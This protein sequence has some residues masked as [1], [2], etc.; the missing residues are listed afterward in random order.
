MFY[1][2]IPC[3]FRGCSILLPALLAGLCWSTQTVS[4]QENCRLVAGFEPEL[5]YH[6]LSEQG[7]IIG[8]DADILRLTLVD[9][10]CELAFQVTP[11][12]RTLVQVKNGDL[13]I[14][15]GASFK[16]ERAK[17]AHY[18]VPYRGQPHVVFENKSQGS[19]ASTLA[20]YLKSG[21]SL[22]VVLGWH[23]TNKIRALLDDP[24]YKPQIEIAPKFELAVKMHDA[25]R[26]DGFLGNPS[27]LA[28]TIGKQALY[29]KYRMI[30]AD[31]DILHYLFSRK[32]VDADL[33]KRF[34][35]RLTEKIAQGF[36]FDVCKKYENMLI[37][38][39]E[40][41]STID[42]NAGN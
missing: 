20:E 4:A 39:C 31:V 36:F 1:S 3:R 9:L 28:A 32:S 27:N 40:F 14:A 35:Q 41:L 6:F 16:D 33:A 5:P 13:D 7:N 10:G 19:G 29:G 18:S 25:N 11:W 17:F 34:N 26:F 30:K 12:K 21:R 38:S 37:S 23:Y 8:I 24:V 42:A 2:F 15:I 22:G